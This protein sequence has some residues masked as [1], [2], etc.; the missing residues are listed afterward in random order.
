M[1]VSYYGSRLSSVTL[2]PYDWL[3][4]GRMAFDDRMCG[5]VSQPRRPNRQLG[6]SRSGSVQLDCGFV[7]VGAHHLAVA[8]FIAKHLFFSVDS[9]GNGEK[10]TQFSPRQ[11]DS[12]TRNCHFPFWPAGGNGWKLL[13]F[14]CMCEALLCPSLS[15]RLPLILFRFLLLHNTKFFTFRLH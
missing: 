12:F 4:I 13:P 9:L 3:S 7:L 14:L 2:A 11:S 1:S 6:P 5:H 8:R 10:R 15:V